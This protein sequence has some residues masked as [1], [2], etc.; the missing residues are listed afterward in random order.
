M[1]GDA[2]YTMFGIRIAIFFI[3]LMMPGC[4][5]DGAGSGAN[6]DA[7]NANVDTTSA[8][9]SKSA[10]V[11]D[12]QQPLLDQSVGGLAIGG[13]SSQKLAQTITAGVT[14]DLIE[15]GFPVACPIGDL[16]VQVQRVANSKPNG[17]VLATQLIPGS[18]LPS[19]AS[20]FKKLSF[21]S[22]PHF[23]KGDVFAVVLTSEGQCAIVQ[24]PVGD[25]YP[26]GNAFFDARPNPPGW[27][28]LPEGRLSDLRYD[29]PFQTVMDVGTIALSIDIKPGSVP[30][31]V[32]PR[33]NGVIPVAILST[34]TFDATTVNPTT[35]RFGKDGTNA[36][37][38]SSA[39]EDV[40]EDGRIDRIFHFK[41]AET[42]IRCEDF[43]AFL[44]GTTFQGQNVNGSDS[45]NTVGCK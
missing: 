26:S 19:P 39:K 45:V 42:G 18:S 21:T 27:L 43:S 3:L 41:T 30:N 37:A 5:G 33:S 6:V 9:R 34:P 16:T 17:E 22:P 36:A 12:Q 8:A 2:T 38:V 14:G 13:A 24:S 20:T 28:P 44:T 35:V 23:A 25:L 11:I 4:G 1:L 31:S 40:N 10:S 32:N 29:L 7:T 15:V